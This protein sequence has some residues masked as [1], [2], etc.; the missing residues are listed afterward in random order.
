MAVPVLLPGIA[1]LLALLAASAAPAWPVTALAALVALVTAVSVWWAVRQCKASLLRLEDDV[2]AQC[3]DGLEP[4]CRSVLPVWAGQVEMARQQTEAAINDLAMRFG[5]LSQ[6][7]AS[8]VSASQ[9]DSAADGDGRQGVVALLTSS[10]T[11]LNSIMSSLRSTL[12]D[13]ESLLQEVHTLSRFTGELKDMAQNVG[14]IAHQTNLLAI[15]AAIE[16]ARAGEVGRG[17]AVVATEVRKLSQLSAETGKRITNTVETVNNA[18]AHTLKV[19][20]QYAQQDLEMT[21]HSER[22]IENVLGQFRSTATGLNDAAEVMRTESQLIQTEISD[23][24]VALQFQDRISQVLSHVR[25]DLDKLSQ[26]LDDAEQ[27]LAV[28]E[29]PQP[30]DS[31]AWLDALTSTYTMPEQYTVHGGEPPATP[32]PA[33]SSSTEITFF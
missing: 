32:S 21:A 5:N 4:L 9:A 7:L 12:K 8:A 30:L 11:D 14:S 29:Y 33:Q 24:L 6:R 19:S 15:N 20:S 31:A 28:G 25:G 2:R 10:E 18:I 22:I 13:K 23:V 17:F 1:G 3:I 27:Q 26:S 16:A